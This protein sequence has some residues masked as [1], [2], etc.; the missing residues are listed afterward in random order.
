MRS[1]Y[2]GED[3]KDMQAAGTRRN[4]PFQRRGGSACVRHHQDEMRPEGCEGA[5]SHRTLTLVFTPWEMDGHR[6][7]NVMD[8]ITS[9]P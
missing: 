9:I 3:L 4:V 1:R 6:S 7:N 2:L 8:I 5:W